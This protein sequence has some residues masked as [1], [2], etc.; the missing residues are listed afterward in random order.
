MSNQMFTA[1]RLGD[2]IVVFLR[3]NRKG[4]DW[5]EQIADASVAR[6]A[7]TLDAMTAASEADARNVVVDPYAIDVIE[8]AAGVKPAAIRERIRAFGPTAGLPEGAKHVPV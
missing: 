4:W 7:G 3:L 2:G 1:N 6:D 5:V 8:S